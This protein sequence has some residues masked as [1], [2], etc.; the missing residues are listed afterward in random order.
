MKMPG[1]SSAIVEIEKIR[2]YCLSRRHPRGRHKAR[3]FLS[4]LGMTFA[5]AEELRAALLGAAEKEDAER[6]TSD[7]YGIRYII[8]FEIIRGERAAR[9]LSCWIILRDETVPRFVT[10]YVL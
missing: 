9:V 5:D 7:Q 1:G 3:V 10:C 8:D 4:A 2:D 6:G